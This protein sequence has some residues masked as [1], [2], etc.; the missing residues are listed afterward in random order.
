MKPYHILYI[1]INEFG[2]WS[3]IFEKNNKH[4]RDNVMTTTNN[5]KTNGQTNN[6]FQYINTESH[7]TLALA[8]EK[9]LKETMATRMNGGSG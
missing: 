2:L 6:N 3:H 8:L 7:I 9:T 4:E 1:Q 5:E